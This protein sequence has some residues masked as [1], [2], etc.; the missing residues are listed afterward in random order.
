M[1]GFLYSRVENVG[2]GNQ[3]PIE[4]EN[5]ETFFIHGVGNGADRCIYLSPEEPGEENAK[6]NNL[7]LLVRNT[8]LIVTDLTLGG[9]CSN[10]YDFGRTLRGLIA[11]SSGKFNEGLWGC[12]G[13]P[14]VVCTDHQPLRI[15]FGNPDGRLYVKDDLEVL[16]WLTLKKRYVDGKGYGKNLPPELTDVFR[17]EQPEQV[18]R[19]GHWYER[20]VPEY[21]KA[22]RNLQTA[23]SRSRGSRCQRF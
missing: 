7:D 19:Y 3:N 21:E 6:A 8:P 20:A 9:S 18:E 4:L 16:E 1:K 11:S 13:D 23:H 12:A 14:L 17:K 10:R 15:S 22:M 2:R 5:G